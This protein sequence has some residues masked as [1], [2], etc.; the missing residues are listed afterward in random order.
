MIS[1]SLY[2]LAIL[3]N[4]QLFHLQP[5]L[6]VNFAC[7][8]LCQ[9]SESLGFKNCSVASLGCL[10]ISNSLLAMLINNQ[11]F[12]LQPDLTINFARKNLCQGLTNEQLFPS[13][14]YS[15]RKLN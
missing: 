7:E 5:D 11:L 15:K 1:N 6:M 4:N 14:F 12:H 3:I 13:D 9:G 2:L 10:V 8:N